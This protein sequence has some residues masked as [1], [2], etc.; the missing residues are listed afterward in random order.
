MRKVLAC[1][2]P[3]LISSS[4][5]HALSEVAWLVNN[6]SNTSAPAT[7]VYIGGSDG[8]DILDSVIVGD[9]STTGAGR[10]T[11]YDSSGTTDTL[12]TILD[13]STA[14]ITGVTAGAGDCRNQY[15]YSVRITSGIT[16]SMTGDANVTILWR[17]R[18]P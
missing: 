5:L 17:N 18:N 13:T 12:L 7:T 15:I 3:V 11:V 2:L 8:D 4:Y 9:C 6:S 16:Y 1:L 14:P 10:L